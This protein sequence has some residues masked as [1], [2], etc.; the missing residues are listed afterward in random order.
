MAHYR[1]TVLLQS[2]GTTDGY[3]V[4]VPALPGLVTEGQTVD[5]AL[6]MARD[7]IA[8]WLD[9]DAPQP[10]PDGVRAMVATVD[11]EV[12]VTGGAVRAPGVSRVAVASGMAD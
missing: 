12:E 4:T 6:A 2:D 7:A 8:L 3:T 11:I 10:E 1:Y 5:D 9:G